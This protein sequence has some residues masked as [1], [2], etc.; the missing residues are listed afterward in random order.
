MRVVKGQSLTRHRGEGEE[1]EGAERERRERG[2][3]ER[4]RGKERERERKREKERGR[5]GRALN[6]AERNGLVEEDEDAIGHPKRVLAPHTHVV[7]TGLRQY[8]AR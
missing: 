4:G 5:Y 2:E 3:R 1:R 8:C 6:D 7:S